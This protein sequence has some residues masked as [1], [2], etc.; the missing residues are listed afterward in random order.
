MRVGIRSDS[1]VA[2]L[3][4]PYDIGPLWDFLSSGDYDEAPKPKPSKKGQKPAPRQPLP[5]RPSWLREIPIPKPPKHMSMEQRREA[6]R[7]PFT[8]SHVLKA[9]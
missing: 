5:T 8:T 1:T 7:Q 2:D 4:R 3:P 9:G 6:W